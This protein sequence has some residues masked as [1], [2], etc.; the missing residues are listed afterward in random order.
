MRPNQ[1][2]IKTEKNG[3]L[4]CPTARPEN[5]KIA[6][7]LDIFVAVRA[8]YQSVN[9]LACLANKSSSKVVWMADQE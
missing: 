6:K 7:C 4:D 9:S 3:D 1:A 2:A 5:S 8:I